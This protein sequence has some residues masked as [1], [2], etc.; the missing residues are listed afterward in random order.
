MIF[1]PVGLA[2]VAVILFFV[3]RSQGSKALDIAST[4]TSTAAGLA[5]EASDVAKEIGAGSFTKVAELKGLVECGRPL[6]AEMSGT[7]CVW[8]RSTVTREYEESYTERDSDG[9]TRTGT[10]R[11][12]ENVSTNE[13][14]TPFMVRDDTGAVEVDPEGAPVEGVKVLSKFEQGDRGPSISIGSFKLSLGALGGGRRTI[15]YRLEESALPLG[16]RVY[17]LGEARDD[18]GALRVAKPAAK[19]GRFIITVKSEEQLLKSAKT[20]SKVSGIIA[21][22]L[23]V[24]AVV[25]LVLILAGLI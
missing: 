4:E 3:G 24:A 19:G 17:V 23:A 11:G 1:I 20:G 12:S 5:T 18:G 14:R 10:R 9:K 16:A 15:G 8:Y 13:R 25:S 22:V 2:A 6:T 21:V 7:E